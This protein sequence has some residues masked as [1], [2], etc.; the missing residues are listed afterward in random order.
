M[1]SNLKVGHRKMLVS[2][3][4][5][6]HWLSE[7]N[8]HVKE[9]RFFRLLLLVMS[10]WFSSLSSYCSHYGY[11]QTDVQLHDGTSGDPEHPE[12][13]CCSALWEPDTAD[14]FL[15]FLHCSLTMFIFYIVFFF[16]FN[17][18]KS[19]N[20]IVFIRI[21][22]LCFSHYASTNLILTAMCANYKC[23][24]QDIS[25]AFESKAKKLK[26]I[27]SSHLNLKGF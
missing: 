10:A 19:N 16:F 21:F 27:V 5:S 9:N 20:V 7:T 17:G 3:H 15:Q 23:D 13:L 6:K 24:L 25:I 18:Q 1:W 11:S 12:N 4:V 2:L 22:V 14:K 8:P 26:Q